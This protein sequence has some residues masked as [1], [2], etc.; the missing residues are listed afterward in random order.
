MNA[1]ATTAALKITVNYYIS[2]GR[3]NAMYT[4]RTFRTFEGNTSSMIPQLTDSYVCNLAAAGNEDEA[5][6]KAA[7]YVEALKERVPDTDNRR[8]LFLD[9]FDRVAHKRRG[10]LSMRETMNLEAL[11]RGEFPFGKHAGTRIDEAPESYVLYFADKLGE[12]GET[13]GIMLAV[14]AACQGVAL[15]KGY[16]AKREAFRALSQHIGTVGQRLDFECTIQW[17]SKRPSDFGPGSVYTH[18]MVHGQTHDVVMYRG[19]KEL[20]AKGDTVRFKATVKSHGEYKGEKQTN[21]TRPA[22]LS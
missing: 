16:I 14:A 9:G 7:E 10:K 13:D 5:E 21:V 6:R 15:Q 4:L 3:L 18:K 22:V 1:A 2:T 8:T 20:G 19:S 11:E 12:L 17:V